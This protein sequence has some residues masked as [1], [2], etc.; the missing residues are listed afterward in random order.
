MNKKFL[1]CKWMLFVFLMC[2]LFTIQVFAAGNFTVSK[3]S[4]TITEGKTGTFSINGSSATGRVDIES[5]DTSVATVSSS[6]IWL[7]NNSSTI[8]VTG[9]KAGTA[10]ITISGT[11]SDGEGIEETVTRTVKI[12]VKATTNNNSTSSG[13]TNNNTTTTKKSTNA[14]L[15][16]LGVTPKEYDFSGF[17]KSKTSYSVTVPNDVDSLKVLYKTED[18]KA[19]VKVS[20]NTGFDVGSNNNIKV[21]VTAEDGKTTKT[22]T[23]KVTKLAEDEE[24]PGNVIED[25]D[26]KELYLTSL[27][28][29][30]LE[31]T[32]EFNEN[33]YSYTATL[34]D[35]NATEVTVKA[36]ANKENAKIDISGNTNLVVGENTINIIVTQDGSSN[37]KVYQI[38]VNKE[39]ASVPASTEPVNNS[40][41][42]DLVGT[43]KSYAGILIGV[44]VFII[45]IIIV[46]IILLVRE[47]KKMQRET[48]EEYN[49]FD[50]DN[51]EFDDKK[52]NF[53]E[54]L[55]KQKNG[56]KEN[57]SEQD[58]E[59]LEEINK[60][61]KEI[62]K[63]EG[64]SV[65]FNSN[66]IDEENSLEE[67][68]KKGRHF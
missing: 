19:T 31:L 32:P 9:K 29:E 50:N 20:G 36:V 7:E 16:T 42:E 2:F 13:S 11:V 64:Q 54:S 21:V 61:T 4:L 38:V 1:K 48:Y 40:N 23:I 18:S 59:T 30:G 46:L 28:I 26:S 12:T 27:N 35:T 5:S 49:V 25:T 24:K 10:T 14:N 3:S 33:T 68:R 65:E 41:N 52:E 37:Q 63:K 44:V 22:Y 51:D 45:L 67:R 43:I 60:Q 56:N 17:S 62:F 47:N 6:S 66:E 15:T 57:I 8:T 34:S 58:K 55:Y 53:I 39:E